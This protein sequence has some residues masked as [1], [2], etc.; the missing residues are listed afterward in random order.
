[1]RHT[2]LAYVDRYDGEAVAGQLVPK[3]DQSGCLRDNSRRNEERFR[4]VCE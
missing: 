1:M 3:Q 2:E 4:L